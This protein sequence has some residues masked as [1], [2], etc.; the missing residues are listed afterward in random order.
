MASHW[1][2][3][4]KAIQMRSFFFRCN[5]SLN[6]ILVTEPSPEGWR[7]RYMKRFQSLNLFTGRLEPSCNKPV[8]VEVFTGYT[9]LPQTQQVSTMYVLMGKKNSLAFRK[10]V[11][12]RVREL[13]CL[14]WG[15]KTLSI[16]FQSCLDSVWTWHLKQIYF[17]STISLLYNAL[18]RNFDRLFE[19]RY[20]LL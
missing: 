9:I 13:F 1:N 17:Y 10:S 19:I 14:R 5:Y 4:T 8:M 18:S 16:I 11:L 6:N 12:S 15:L 20:L 7:M 3:L 2:C